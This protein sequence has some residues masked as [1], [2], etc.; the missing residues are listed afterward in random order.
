MSTLRVSSSLI[1]LRKSSLRKYDVGTKMEMVTVVGVDVVTDP[2]QI[3]SY[4]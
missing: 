2:G 1:V 4:W 3:A